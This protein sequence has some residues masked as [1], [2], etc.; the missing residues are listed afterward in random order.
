MRR[1]INYEDYV[2]TFTHPKGCPVKYYGFGTYGLIALAGLVA[3]YFVLGVPLM[4]LSYLFLA[5]LVI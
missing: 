4:V 3:L 5:D 2:I 1:L